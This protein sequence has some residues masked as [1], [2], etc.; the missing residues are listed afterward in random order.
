MILIQEVILVPAPISRL[1]KDEILKLAKGRCKHGHS[2]LEHY[3]CYKNDVEDTERVGFI[4]IE[5]SNLKA[6]FGIMLSYCI[7]IRGSDEILFDVITEKDMHCGE[8]DKRIV[9]HCIED[10]KKFDR[11]IGHYSTKFDIP[12]IRTRALILGL[13]FPEYGD[14]NHTDTYYMAKHK[15]CLSS[16]RQN[17]VAEA[18]QGE[19]IKSRIEPKY[20]IP[21]LQG[22]K[23]ALDYI[24]D[25]NKRD[26]LQLEG[27]YN[28]LERFVR[29][30]N[31]SI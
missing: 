18:V 21:A 12:Y 10:M 11:L 5:S 28:K 15:L 8:L 3:Q 29:R 9:K 24:L 16:N 7:K 14:I 19:D 27:N 31:K 13:D 22:N 2:Y 17:V 26:V 20:W 30:I 6:N 25:H 23:K 1:R 4:D